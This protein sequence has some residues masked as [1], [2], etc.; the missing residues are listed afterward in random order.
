[1]IVVR[2]L[3]PTCFTIALRER[4]L[5]RL[6]EEAQRFVSKTGKVRETVVARFPSCDKRGLQGRRG[7][8]SAENLL[9][10]SVTRITGRGRHSGPGSKW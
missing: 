4:I 7:Q 10:A 6:S 2:P 1:M 9:G 5:R 8:D 3:N